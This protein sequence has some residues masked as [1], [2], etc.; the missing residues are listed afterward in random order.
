[1]AGVSGA[2]FAFCSDGSWMSVRRAVDAAHMNLFLVLAR[3][4]DVVGILHTHEGIHLDPE[5]LFDAQRHVAGEASLAI[6]QT[7]ERGPRSLKRLSGGS[8]SQSG[9][10]D[11]FGSY[12]I[13]GVRRVL[14]GHGGASLLVSGNPLN[15]R[16]KSCVRRRYETLDVGCE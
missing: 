13:A 8:H 5:C 16:H 9:R 10:L 3:L 4:R 15:L 12:E 14:H 6:E 2:R 11:E 7:G 1:M